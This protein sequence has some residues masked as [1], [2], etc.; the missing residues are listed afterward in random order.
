MS[1]PW[2]GRSQAVSEILPEQACP[3]SKLLAHAHLLKTHMSPQPC[4]ISLH[5]VSDRPL[6]LGIGVSVNVRIIPS[7]AGKRR[8]ISVI[9]ATGEPSY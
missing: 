3:S 9:C 2:A 5:R 1:C 4:C 7:A 8:G 6:R